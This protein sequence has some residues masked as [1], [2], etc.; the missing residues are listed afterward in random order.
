MTETATR[1][2][3]VWSARHTAEL[4]G[5]TYRQLDYLCRMTEF[6]PLIAARGSGSRRRF[7]RHDVRRAWAIFRAPPWARHAVNRALIAQ[8]NAAYVVIVG[9]HAYTSSGAGLGSLIDS[10][11][12]E[13]IPNLQIIAMAAGPLP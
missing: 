6:A 8:P 13:P 4:A 11:V 5:V 1:D 2:D 9:P 12:Q 3:V 7:T 10:L